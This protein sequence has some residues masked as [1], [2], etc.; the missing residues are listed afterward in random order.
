MTLQQAS[1][2][3]KKI[4]QNE[5]V[6]QHDS[7]NPWIKYKTIHELEVKGQFYYT[8][9]FSR[10]KITYL[11]PDTDGKLL[12]HGIDLKPIIDSEHP[13]SIIF[14]LEHLY[15]Q[16]QIVDKN[17]AKVVKK[18]IENDIK[19]F[20]DTFK[21]VWYR[22]LNQYGTVEEMEHNV[23]P[24]VTISK[25]K[26]IEF[27]HMPETTANLQLKTSKRS[28]SV[29]TSV[30]HNN[31]Q[32]QQIITQIG[33]DGTILAILYAAQ[34]HLPGKSHFGLALIVPGLIQ[35]EQRARIIT[36]LQKFE[37]N[38]W[39]SLNLMSSGNAGDIKL[40]NKGFNVA[41]DTNEAII[42]ALKQLIMKKKTFITLIL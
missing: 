42:K 40:L 22:I 36:Q 41:S 19:Y 30:Y 1:H 7:T 11:I 32:I 4:A 38:G 37:Q 35:E 2:G 34:E 13:A 29:V 15:D 8:N 27:Y 24:A 31:H 14:M 9:P 5:I 16:S 6:P 39:V 3:I 33:L 26:Y 23:K 25:Q 12:S 21:A 28:T 20:E 10:A 18:V 17:L